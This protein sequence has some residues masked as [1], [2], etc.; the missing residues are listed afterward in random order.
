MQ[1]CG[2]G[3]AG[4]RRRNRNAKCRALGFAQNARQASEKADAI[5]AMPQQQVQRKA[6]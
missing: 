3:T 1:S 2:N 6:I 5:E 4:E